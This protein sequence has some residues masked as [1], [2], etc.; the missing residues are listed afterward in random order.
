MSCECPMLEL[1]CNSA[2]LASFAKLFELFLKIRNTPVNLADFPSELV[3]VEQD[4]HAARTGKL[5]MT[6]YPSDAF[7]AFAATFAADFDFNAVK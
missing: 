5:A 1:Q 4:H 6:F 2:P 7:L 3:R